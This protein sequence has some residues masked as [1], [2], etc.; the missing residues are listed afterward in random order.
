MAA[1]GFTGV[2]MRLCPSYT[3]R[4]TPRPL[5]DGVYYPRGRV[6]LRPPPHR[7]FVLLH[8]PGIGPWC[9]PFALLGG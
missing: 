1:V 3:W 6:E 5:D 4:M 7:D 2:R 9:G 8:P